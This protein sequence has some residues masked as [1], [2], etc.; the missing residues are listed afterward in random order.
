MLEQHVTGIKAAISGIFAF[1]TALWGW[2]GWL[3]VGWVAC[4][5]IDYVS[6]SLVAG[7]RGEWSSARAR[8][9]LRRKGGMILIVL[10]GAGAD[11]LLGALVNNLPVVE[12]PFAYSVL[13]CPLVVCWY[14]VTELGSI[15]ENAVLLGAPCPAFLTGVLRVMKS[16]IGKAGEQMS[17]E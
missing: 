5:A 17:N 7:H 16:T 10:C 11:L 1:F 13:I 9:G 8:D 6:G 2:M 4:M 14:I 15:I 12:L 3:V